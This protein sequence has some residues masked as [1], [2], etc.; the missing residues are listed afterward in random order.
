MTYLVTG[1]CGSTGRYVAAQLL[2]SGCDV[3]GID[4]KTPSSKKTSAYL[5]QFAKKKVKH[6]LSIG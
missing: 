6:L 3:I 1:V 5:K 2:S 4:I